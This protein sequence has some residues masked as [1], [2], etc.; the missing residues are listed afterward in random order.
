LLGQKHQ[1]WLGGGG[2]RRNETPP[3]GVPAKNVTY[4]TNQRGKRGNSN[5]YHQV[6]PPPPPPPAR[7]WSPQSFPPLAQGT[8]KKGKDV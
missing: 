4:C 2:Y 6:T 7:L 3:P 8:R 1:S 5:H